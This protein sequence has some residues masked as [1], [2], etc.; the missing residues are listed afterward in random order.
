MQLT[1]MIL[2]VCL[3]VAGVGLMVDSRIAAA[4]LLVGGIV[5][6]VLAVR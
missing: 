1:G 4:A 6:L 3:I 5:T 2:P